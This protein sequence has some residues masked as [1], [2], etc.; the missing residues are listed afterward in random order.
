MLHSHLKNEQVNPS[1]GQNPTEERQ[2]KVG[3]Y[4]L[5]PTADRTKGQRKETLSAE[6]VKM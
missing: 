6:D 2:K 3:E 1:L 5:T 4:Q